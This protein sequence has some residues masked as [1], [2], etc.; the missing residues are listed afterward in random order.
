[1]NLISDNLI[2]NLLNS[3]KQDDLWVNFMEAIGSELE[4]MKV[5]ILS[6]KDLFNPNTEEQDKLLDLS[7]MFGYNPN[8][9]LDNSLE[10]I[11]SEYLSIPYRIKLKTTYDGYYIIFKQINAN[12][13]I[14][15]YYYDG[16]KLIKAMNYYSS[17]NKILDGTY[18]YGDIFTYNEADKNFSTLLSAETIYLDNEVYLDDMVGNYHWNLD[19][20]VNIIPTKHLGIEYYPQGIMKND[21]GEDCILNKYWYYY[22]ETG[23]NYTRRVPII[24]HL[25]LQLSVVIKENTA[26]DY[27]TP[28]KNYTIDDLKLNASTSFTLN[29]KFVGVEPIFLDNNE[30]LDQLNKW[31]LDTKSSGGQTI[32][33]DDFKYICCGNGKHSLNNS[34]NFNIFAYK[35]MVL[36]YNFDD[37]D[38][39]DEIKDYSSNSNNGIL[40]GD[41]VKVNGITGKTIN[42]N[43]STYVRGNDSLNINSN[44]KFSISFWI[45]PNNR[46]YIENT[47]DMCVFELQNFLKVTYNYSDR[48]MKLHYNGNVLNADVPYNENT[49]IN[50][51]IYNNVMTVYVNANEVLN[52][53][54]TPLTTDTYLYIGVDSSVS[55]HFIGMIDSFYIMDKFF[56]ASEK[57]YIMEN[58]LSIVTHLDNMLARYKLS[59]FSEI[60][61]TNK[62][63]LIQSYVSGLDVNDEFIF[64]TDSE[65]DT[66]TVF[67]GKLKHDSLVSKYFKYK[68]VQNNGLPTIITANESGE[69]YTEDNHLIRGGI[70]YE[71][72]IYTIYPFDKNYLS[73]VDIDIEDYVIEN[74]KHKVVAQ[75]H[76]LIENNTLSGYVIRSDETRVP[77]TTSNGEINGVTDVIEGT[78][79]ETNGILTLY[80][81]EDVK[82]VI[83]SYSYFIDLNMKADENVFAEYKIKEGYI[84]EIGLENANHELTAYM[85]FPKVEFNSIQDF[86]SVGFY[87]LK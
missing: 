6:K 1:M 33:S 19:R 61:D 37:E 83:I 21:E 76:D 85:T 70:D 65:M 80:L 20:G 58:K 30:V 46:F 49:Y 18:V 54:M 39:S 14:Y 41:T 60:Y 50:I 51:E 47:S 53:N 2:Y 55:N 43:G 42:F 62:I 79:D 32:T 81:S 73:D 16:N 9:I 15:N 23:V 86:I 59:P 40:Y 72:G 74:N 7:E 28:N 44:D 3:L 25:G 17:L 34:A 52:Y 22:L 12:G 68:Y 36:F 75:L 26:Y 5:H 27:L 31:T 82:K 78:I 69:F 24:P 11:K 35:N 13:D 63:R 77:F 84:S 10:M 38:Y 64:K 48:M 4:L 57:N 56:T 87:M 66:S 71:N 45:N 8:L 67:I 29:K